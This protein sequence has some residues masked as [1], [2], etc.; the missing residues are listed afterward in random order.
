MDDSAK[1]VLR[2]IIR[3]I[4]SNKLQNIL[5]KWEHLSKKQFRSLEFTQAKWLLCDNLLSLCE[6]NDLSMKHVTEL[7][8]IYRIENPAQG[9]WNVCQLIDPSEEAVT[10]DSLTFKDSFKAHLKHLISHVSVKMKKHEDNA[11]WIRIAWGDNFTQPNH[12]NPTYVVHHLQTPYVF[13]SGLT[14][15][16]KPFL[17]QAL[18][19]S[20]HYGG[21]KDVHLSGRCLTALRDL[22]MRQYKQAFP[23]K[24]PRLLQEKSP[25][26]S[27][28]NIETEHAKH[29][30]KRLQM[31]AE[32]FGEGIL[33]KLETAV[34]KLETR[35][36]EN[37]MP[38]R[39][40][41]P[42]RGVV[43]FSSSNL[44]E[45]LK[46]CVSSGMASAPVTPLLSSITQKGRNYFVITDKG[47][48]V[49]HTQGRK[50]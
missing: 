24:H 32:A 19:P 10:V 30:E 34:Y 49:S 1:Q 33:P 21:L 37:G 41:E 6:E 38:G 45:S 2:K 11:I 36:R 16:H 26:P 28:P 8:M 3:R 23:V 13:V 46:N 40:E 42:F 29:T 12:L 5:S 47:P 48:G 25:V 9:S 7:E 43:K 44:L 15:K 27:H 18:I 35:F 22:L 14:A 39:R 31:A 50:I 20:T 17:H 4:P